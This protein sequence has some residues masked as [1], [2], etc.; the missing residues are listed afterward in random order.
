[1]PVRHSVPF[2]QQ[3][4]S[5][6]PKAPYCFK[7]VRHK[8]K[9]LDLMSLFFHSA[10]LLSSLHI[11][12]SLSRL[13]SCLLFYMSSL[14]IYVPCAA[15]TTAANNVSAEEEAN[16]L[17]ALTQDA[18]SLNSSQVEQLVS[19]LEV[20]LSGPNVS[21]ALGQTSVHITNNLLNAS[22]EAVASSSTR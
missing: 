2:R 15:T 21:L 5:F 10:F 8:S 18:S 20:L 19:Q 13:S 12:F 6:T 1:M 16:Q 11:S 14:F 3:Y 4:T 7:P 9:N 17:L 22:V